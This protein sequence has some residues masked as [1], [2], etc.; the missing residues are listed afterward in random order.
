MEI[1]VMKGKLEMMKH[2][3]AAAHLKRME[4]MN[5]ELQPK[6]KMRICMLWNI[7]GITSNILTKKWRWRGKLGN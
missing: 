4:N 6:K 2:L 5:D 3:Q 1:R 7:S